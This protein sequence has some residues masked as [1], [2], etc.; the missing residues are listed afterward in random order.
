[1]ND[2]SSQKPRRRWLWLPV[3]VAGVWW[4][5]TCVLLVD[6]TEFV[7]VERFGRLSAVYDTAEQRGLHVKWPWPL[8][9][10]RRFDARVQLLDPG[11]REMLTR[12]RKN[13]MLG[14]YV[15]WKIAAPSD[16]KAD[17]NERPVVRFFR[18]L[19]SRESA[20]ARLR[21]HLQSV[22][23]A[24]F[25][26][27]ELGSLLNVESSE[28][29]PQEGD[30]GPLER[31]AGEVADEFRNAEGGQPS[32]EKSLGIEVVEVGIKR[33]NFPAGNRM[34]VHERMKSERRK[35]AER[36]RG[37]GLAESKVIRSRADFQSAA[38]L[39]K[40]NAD[41]E[42]IRGAA[43]AEAL[44]VLNAAQALD[45]EF[46]GVVRRLDAYR[47]ILGPQTTLVL[48]ASSELFKMMTDGVPPKPKTDQTLPPAGESE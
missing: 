6:E 36:Y 8:E 37:E 26:Q 5:T 30:A 28:G 31:L 2:T 10:V 27:L 33:I 18:S 12:D 23:S 7:L 40:A 13:V 34:A 15:C 41:A 35:I 48:S 46:Y 11:A 1:M 29:G 42:R 25:G 3:V 39:A 21:T 4:A 19:G 22:L 9:T 16:G 32:L 24:R 43:E 14:G 44:K 38:V 17:L 47:A 20:E 45:P